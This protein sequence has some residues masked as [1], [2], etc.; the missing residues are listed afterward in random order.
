MPPPTPEEIAAAQ[1]ALDDLWGVG[2]TGTLDRAA[3]RQMLEGL[4]IDVPI[5]TTDV[6]DAA[7]AYL[8]A[9]NAA[10]QMSPWGPSSLEDIAKQPAVQQAKAALI[11][12]ANA[13]WGAQ[14]GGNV[15]ESISNYVTSQVQR[16][17]ETVS[18]E[19]RTSRAYLDIP[20]PEEFLNKFETGLATHVQAQVKAGTLSRGAGLWLLDNPDVLYN[21]Y[22]ADLGARAAKGEQIFKPVGVGGAPEFLGTRPGAVETRQTES[23]TK[24]LE[25]A[26]E[27]A[28]SAATSVQA[29]GAGGGGGT[30]QRQTTTTTEQ[31]TATTEKNKALSQLTQTEEIY[32]RPNLNYAYAISP[33]EF[34]QK[35]TDLE[36][37][38][39]GQRGAK[40]REAETATAPPIVLPRVVR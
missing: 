7:Q 21:D 1:R 20:T 9:Q 37:L 10:A 26:Q 13:L 38:Y 22:M 30:T 14:A 35:R 12:R 33:L 36:M 16:Q 29:G 15:A 8:D 31:Q 23:E 19:Q 40:R 2:T 18:V 4:G 17:Q 5:N 32:A 11:D 39:Q 3:L 27:Q 34:L 25:Q 24:A 28:Q 6:T